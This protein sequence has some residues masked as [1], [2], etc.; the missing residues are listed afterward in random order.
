M[1]GKVKEIT[2]LSNVIKEAEEELIEKEKRLVGEKRKFEEM[3]DEMSKRYP[4]KD[5]IIHL[6]VGKTLPS[7]LGLAKSFAFFVSFV[8]SSFLCIVSH[9]LLCS[10]FAL[11]SL[12]CTLCFILS[13]FLH[14]LS[15]LFRS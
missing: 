8:G 4:I 1:E 6:N 9:S 7:I 12:F 5:K 15:Y 13:Y 11:S 3:K 10:L 14:P 2:K